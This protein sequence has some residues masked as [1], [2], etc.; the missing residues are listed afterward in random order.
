MPTL[1]GVDEPRRPRPAGRTGRACARRRRRRPRPPPAPRDER[2]PA[3]P[4]EDP[5][6]ARG[7][8]VAEERRGRAEHIELDRQRP[9]ATRASARRRAARCTS[10]HVAELAALGER[11][12]AV[13]VAARG[14]D[15][16]TVAS[17]SRRGTRRET[18]PRPDR[19]RR[20]SRSAVAR[21][22]IARAR[23]RA[24]AGCRGRRRAR[25]PA[26]RDATPRPSAPC[27][28]AVRLRAERGPAQTRSSAGQPEQANALGVGR[29]SPVADA[30]DRGAELALEPPRRRPA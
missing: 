7:V 22:A 20:R 16:V 11:R 13:A 27:R 3:W 26:C 28:S 25:R 12:L 4:R 18:A 15:R 17:S 8:R 5:H 9:A 1:P 23:P 21:R 19:R 30:R 29:K 2:R 24:P 6:V 14:T 10:R